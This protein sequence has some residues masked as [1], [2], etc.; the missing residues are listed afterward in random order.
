ME[1]IVII[2]LGLIG[3]SMGLGLKRAAGTQPTQIIG[4]D[5]DRSNEDAALRKYKSI[6]S[7]AQDLESG[8]RDAN[9]II[10]STPSSAVREVLAAID[11]FLDP[12]AVVTD[13]LSTKE[14]VMSW[15]G[16]LLS[17]GNFVGGHPLSRT[18]D[19]E[20]PGESEQPE[21]DLF[22]N[23]PYC[24]TPLPRAGGD[25]LN[26]VIALAE[27]LGAN[28]LFI[29]PWEHDSLFAA[30]SH[31]PLVASAA[32][33]RLASGSPSWQDIG[34][35]ARSR[36]DALTSPLEG[37]PGPLADALVANRQLLL[38]WVDQY[39]LVL[40]D[41]REMIAQGN[42]TELGAAIEGA[43]DARQQ[44]LKRNS[45]QNQGAMGGRQIEPSEE[46]KADLEQAV[47]DSRPGTRIFGRYLSDRIFGK[48]EQK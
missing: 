5:P 23:A 9:L 12:S 37:E 44:W 15:A 3:N 28:P 2:G 31:L 11:P 46:L 36:F 43:H 34:S 14:Q 40:Q 29:D 45:T 24:I 42:G 17:Q 20:S 4:F 1:K 25:A 47:R 22:E 33:M 48:K 18:V 27:S 6:D 39:L 35:L 7:V 13:T 16:E 19:T 41:L 8:V 26:R 38:H 30:A 10:I 32:L 21:A